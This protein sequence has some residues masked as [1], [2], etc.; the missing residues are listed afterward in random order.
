VLHGSSILPGSTSRC[1]LV[2]S[3]WEED[4]PW[5]HLS[6]FAGFL[7]DRNACNQADVWMWWRLKL[8]W[9]VSCGLCTA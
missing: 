3:S 9:L 2:S 6:T 5:A 1:F 7:P 4:L 8:A